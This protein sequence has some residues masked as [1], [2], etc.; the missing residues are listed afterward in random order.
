MLLWEKKTERGVTCL[1]AGRRSRGD[2]AE[3]TPITQRER[4]SAL[5]FSP[6]FVHTSMRPCTEIQNTHARTS[7]RRRHWSRTPSC[8]GV[9]ND[10]TKTTCMLSKTHHSLLS[11]S[12]EKC[13]R[14]TL[15]LCPLFLKHQGDRNNH[16]QL[17]NASH[18]MQ[19]VNFFFFLFLVRCFGLP[20]TSFVL[21]IIDNIS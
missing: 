14:R 15:A 17:H 20:L 5:L 12:I 19:G 1:Q 7:T 13:A 8:R 18:L 2:N 9:N 3:C 6:S 11:T 10:S 16:A 21:V 4:Q